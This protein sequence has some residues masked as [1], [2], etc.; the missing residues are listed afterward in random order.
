MPFP[1]IPLPT[2]TVRLG[3]TEVTIRSLDGNQVRA[4]SETNWEAP[5]TAEGFVVA[6]CVVDGGSEE[7]AR[8]WLLTL[9]PAHRARLVIECLQFSGIRPKVTEEEVDPTED[10]S[11]GSTPPDPAPSD[12]TPGEP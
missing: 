3:A 6:S 12:T 7:D 4:L 2:T 10:P 5:R 11:Q 8:A 1:T 9:A